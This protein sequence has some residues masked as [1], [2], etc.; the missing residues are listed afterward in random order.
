MQ[1]AEELRGKGA[2]GAL[3]DAREENR[4]KLQAR[5]QGRGERA[6]RETKPK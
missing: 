6:G 4:A 5:R 2:L 3:R 1:L